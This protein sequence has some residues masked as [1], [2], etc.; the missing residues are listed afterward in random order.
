M[1]LRCSKRRKDGK[2]H[3]YWSVVE[4]RRCAD[5]RVFQRHVLY[6][7]ELNGR[8][9]ASWR[10]TVEAIT[11][12]AGQPQQVALFPDEY[13]PTDLMDGETILK[14]RLSAMT[15]KRPR[16]WGAC[17]LG[18][19][20]GKQLG[21]DDFWKEHLSPSRKGTRWDLVLQTVAL[22]RLIAPGS[23]WCLHRQWFDQSALADLIG[24]DATLAEPP[25]SLR[26]S[27]QAR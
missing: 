13:A 3:L 23:E 12:D 24:G 19:E 21:L 1:F 16:Q 4:N 20:L 14:V 6:L 10:K 17:W 26:M 11:E 15:L 9:E 7:G 27:R 25:P 18:C 22:Y 5:G 2:E 8:Q